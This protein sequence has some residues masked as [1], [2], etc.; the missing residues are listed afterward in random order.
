MSDFK[1][2]WTAD[3]GGL[4]EEQLLDYLEGRLPEEERQA[5]EALLADEG[6][7]SDALEGLQAIGA[8]EA[9][10]MKHRLNA[11]LAQALKK[12]R[13]SRRGIAEGRWTLYAIIILLLL[14]VVCF[15]AMWLMKHQS[16]TP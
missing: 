16:P 7:E 6:M 10:E 14:A 13:R 4:S 11:G 1:D 12:K 15:G 3:E 5:V 9:R 2:I 8:A